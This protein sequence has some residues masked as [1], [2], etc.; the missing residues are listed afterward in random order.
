MSQFFRNIKYAKVYWDD[1]ARK[2]GIKPVDSQPASFAQQPG[3][4]RW[5]ASC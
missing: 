5:V 2:I 3:A 4:K 1:K